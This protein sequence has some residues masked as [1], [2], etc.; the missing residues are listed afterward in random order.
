MTWT[1]YK[2]K[3]AVNLALS[4]DGLC[5][6]DTF[7]TI[8]H[9]LLW[10]CV[11][12]HQWFATFDNVRCGSWCRKCNQKNQYDKK[13]F[14]YI[15]K[16]HAIENFGKCNSEH[17]V[18]SHEKLQWECAKAHR[19]DA[20]Y[21][22]VVDYGRWCPFCKKSRPQERLYC[23]LKEIFNEATYVIFYN[24]RG[25]DWLKTSKN[26]YQEFDIF[27]KSKISSFS[28]A[29]EYNG[30]QHYAPVKNF[31]GEKTFQNI[32][33]LDKIKED[34]VNQHRDDVKY[35]VKIPYY[36]SIELSNVRNLLRENNVEVY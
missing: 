27:I 15:A 17:Y 26:S 22:N 9:K 28:L 31:G 33:R 23:I 3:D 21:H 32:L 29:V 8:K 35:F 18:S 6:S 13:D 30:I 36:E 10:R 5:L 24:Y 11:R 20:S 14:L 34:K 25:F 19:W 4:N 1:K 7:V 16:N 12:G 2:I